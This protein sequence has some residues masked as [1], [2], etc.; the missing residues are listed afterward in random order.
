MLVPAFVTRAGSRKL[1][2][3]KKTELTALVL[4]PILVNLRLTNRVTRSICCHFVIAHLSLAVGYV[5][6]EACGLKPE[7]KPVNA[8]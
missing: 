8:K 3:S 4:L 5:V 1:W 7:R 6:I 2:D